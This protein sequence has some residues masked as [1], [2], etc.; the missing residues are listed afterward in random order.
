MKS[1]V[2]YLIFFLVLFLSIIFKFG[3]HEEIQNQID[4]D[5]IRT[6]PGYVNGMPSKLIKSGEGYFQADVVV[7]DYEVAGKTY[8]SYTSRTGKAGALNYFT[9]A[10][11]REIAYDTRNP[12]VSMLRHYYDHPSRNRDTLGRILFVVALMGA[13]PAL[14]LTLLAATLVWIIKRFF[15]SS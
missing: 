5:K 6:S 8:H 3:G 4:F 2:G 12:E 15:F 10:K 13:I 9:D 7:F 11:F 14:L 1:F